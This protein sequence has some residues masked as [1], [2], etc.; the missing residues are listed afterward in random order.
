[1][2]RKNNTLWLTVLTQEQ[3]E[4]TCNYW[5]CVTVGAMAHTA[6]ET[7]RGLM[8]YLTERGLKLSEPLTPAGEWSSQEI[9][10]TY[11]ER[12]HMDT[13]EF[14]ALNPVIITRA[15]SNGD[16]TLALITEED[17]VRTVHTLNPNVH[18]RPVFDYFVTAK[19]M[20]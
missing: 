2:N 10:G 19:A 7:E 15:M 9:I 13:K 3:H 5:Y 1:M 20:R 14:Y 17:G 4:H 12:M 18:D 16:Y 6:F 8:Q 11:N